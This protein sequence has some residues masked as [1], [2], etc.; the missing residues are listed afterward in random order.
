[1]STSDLGGGKTTV[2]CFKCGTEMQRVWDGGYELQP[3][4]GLHFDTTGAY[5]S[6]A[7]DP[8]DGSS[9]NIII[10][11]E[12]IVAGAREGRVM[13]DQRH[14]GIVVT[15]DGGDYAC[16]FYRPEREAVPWDPDKDYGE[17]EPLS[18]EPEEVA[19]AKALH[20]TPDTNGQGV[21]DEAAEVALSEEERAEIAWAI[22]GGSESGPIAAEGKLARTIERILAAHTA[23]ALRA[24]VALSEEEREALDDFRGCGC[25][26]YSDTAAKVW[27]DNCPTVGD[28]QEHTYSEDDC[29]K[30]MS[31]AGLVGRLLAARTAALR[32]VIEA[33]A[34]ARAWD[35][36]YE[37]GYDESSFDET[38]RANPYRASEKCREASQGDSGGEVAPGATDAAKGPQIGSTAEQP[39]SDHG[40]G[41]DGEGC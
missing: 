14:V 20:R 35:E 26:S 39:E 27:P 38:G 21:G 37:R 28:D 2:P 8:M 13:L 31:I 11:D 19:E 34:L 22:W 3:S 9:L 23:A 41:E 7:F 29:V 15:V 33:E 32:P 36:G 16:G 1:V 4:D 18:V 25:C 5:G 30:G 40:P 6:T 10:C 24:E 17:Q 12:C